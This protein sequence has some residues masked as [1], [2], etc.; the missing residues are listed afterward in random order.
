[1]RLLSLIFFT[2]L[3][4]AF[5][6]KFLATLILACFLVLLL[7]LALAQLSLDDKGRITV[8]F[9]VAS[10]QLLLVG[11]AVFFGS[12]FISMDLTQK[13]LWMILTK[14]VR[15][16]LFFLGRYLSLAFLLVLATIAMSFLL[17]SF[18]IFLDIPIQRILFYT[19]FGFL[20]E[21]WLILAFVVFFSS[22]VSSYL[23]VFYCLSLFFI[24]HFVDSLYFFLKENSG[25][26]SLVF[27]KVFYLI[28]N[29]ESV[30]W[31]TQ[32]I[33]QDSLAFMDFITSSLYIF[34]WIGF[35]LS[36]GLILMEK[37]EF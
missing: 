25:F 18:F 30:N 35:V 20:L 26:F 15:P 32:L 31:K 24:S 33:N 8:D 10:I 2:S 3:R 17:V 28:P 9:G 7:S 5:R 11:L 6:R 36:G 19:L 29:L 23:V 37:R 21:S 4:Q 27:Q 12:N 1:M 14:P 34:V 16:S 13:N 22:Y